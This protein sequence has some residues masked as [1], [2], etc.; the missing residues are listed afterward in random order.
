[1]K[2]QLC[3]RNK[4]VFRAGFYNAVL[5]VCVDCAMTTQGLVLLGGIHEQEEEEEDED[6]LEVGN[7]EEP[8][9]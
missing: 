4:A 8:G 2:C 1:M 7:Q 9:V 6:E 5:Y 3:K